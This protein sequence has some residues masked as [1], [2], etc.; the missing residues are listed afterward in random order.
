MKEWIL[1]PAGNV[2]QLGLI[3]VKG[4]NGIIIGQNDEQWKLL[5]ILDK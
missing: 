5:R 4:K 3:S 1:L 2:K